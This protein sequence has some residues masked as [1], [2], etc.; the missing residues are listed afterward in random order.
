MTTTSPIVSSPSAPLTV[1]DAAALASVGPNILEAAALASVVKASNSQIAP[2]IYKVDATFR[3]TATVT[4]N[5]DEA[6]VKALGMDWAMLALLLANHVNGSTLT[7]VL[8]EMA[9]HHRLGTKP[10][11]SVKD[12]V[13]AEWD[14]FGLTTSGTRSGKTLVKGK[15]ERV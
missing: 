6:E 13:V 1:A 7:H 15:I 5:E 4:K 9:Q 12:W 14:Q 3:V 8:S 10:D 11:Q 2:G